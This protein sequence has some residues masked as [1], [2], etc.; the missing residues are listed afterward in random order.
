VFM[1]MLRGGGFIIIRD[2]SVFSSSP[3]CGCR[4]V[5]CKERNVTC[6]LVQLLSVAKELAAASSVKETVLW[7][8]SYGMKSVSYCATRIQST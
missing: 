7:Q 6:V 2:I 5:L 1:C 8:H 3:S 4:I